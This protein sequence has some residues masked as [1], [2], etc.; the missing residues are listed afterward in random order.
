MS[1][2]DELFGLKGKTA[3]VTGG[4]RG[5]GQTVALGLA[6]AGAEIAII[7]RSGADE[8]V[9]LIE[10]EGGKAYSL[11][12]DVTKEAD[13]DK[14]MAEIIKRSKRLDVVFNN[15]GVCIHKSTLEASIAEW[16][17]VIDIN[18]TGEY[19]VARAAGRVMIE[20][21]IEGSIINMASMSGTIVN[22]PQWQASYNAS[23]AGVIHMTRSLA[24][25]WCEHGIRVNSLSPG[26]IATPMSVDTPA[27]LKNAW[28]PLIPQHRMGKPEELV[29]AVIYLASGKSGYTSGSD[30]IVDGCYT[31]F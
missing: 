26:Y 5:I 17:E 6:K 16:R 1:Y 9:K 27:E 23:K 29:G 31:C 30:L 14:A 19:I 3:L 28:M 12:A 22:I 7:S 20:H 18:L 2:L 15:A 24:V 10:K 25:E 13:V 21:K 11:I 8:T 4:G